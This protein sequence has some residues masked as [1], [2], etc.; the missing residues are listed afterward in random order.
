[1]D[2]RLSDLLTCP[3]CGPGH[4]LILLP[5]EVRDRRVREGMLGCAN[6]RERYPV[7]G[8]VADLRVEGSRGA[9]VWGDA[10]ENL[11]G[12]IGDREEAV[13]LAALMGL[14]DAVGVVLVAGP[15]AIHGA[16]LAALVD[17]VEVVAIDGG[18]GPGVSR[19]LVSDRIPFRTGSMRGVALTGRRVAL[20]EEGAR[21]LGTGARLV[22]DPLPEAGRARLGDAGLEMIAEE[23]GVV[24]SRRPA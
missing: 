6:C 8:G 16:E 9:G 11:S 13:R 15:A 14:A 4:G 10:D 3:R 5:G 24:V 23:E 20:L 22:V 21:L 1:M 7:A 17:G 12:G 18:A 19:V 2:V